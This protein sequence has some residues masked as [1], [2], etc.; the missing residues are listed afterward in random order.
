M[1][2]LTTNIKKMTTDDFKNIAAQLRRPS[3]KDGIQIG[4]SMNENNISMTLNTIKL[5]TL[6]ANDTVLELG[7]GNGGHIKNIFEKEKNVHYTGLEVS[8]EMH[9]EAIKLN[10][11]TSYIGST[12]FLIYEGRA[13]PFKDETYNH[14]ITVNT[15]YFWENPQ[16]LITEMFRVL[17][18]GGTCAI[19]FADR[20][21]MEI[22]PFTKFGFE[23]YDIKKMKALISKTKFVINQIDEQEEQV[24]SKTGEKANRK[25]FTVQLKK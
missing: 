14:I 5:A 10:Q 6:K 2:K 19:T 17:K 12:T 25:Y 15:I 1:E 21:F 22:L 20:S 4:E 18:K 24:V 13:I 7:H 23:L 3:G 11:N 9:N 8:T 16:M